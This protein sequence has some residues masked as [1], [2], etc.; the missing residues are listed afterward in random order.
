MVRR[1]LVV[2]AVAVF[3]FPGVLASLG[4]GDDKGK[5]DLPT[6]LSQ[7]APG[8]SSAPTRAMP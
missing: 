4:C 2:I 1:I 5:V 8:K 6:N 7:K 3:M